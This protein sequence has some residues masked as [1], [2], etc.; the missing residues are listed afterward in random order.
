MATPKDDNDK[1]YSNI[2]FKTTIDKCKV[3]NGVFSNYFLKAFMA[4][5]VSSADFTVNC[6]SAAGNYTL[7]NY[8]V[9]DSFI[10]PMLNKVKL[11]VFCRHNAKVPN[12]KALQHIFSWKSYAEIRNS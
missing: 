3:A 11:L 2:F 6:K 12:V 1:E 8:Q 9:D 10:P 7:T 4:N 5:F